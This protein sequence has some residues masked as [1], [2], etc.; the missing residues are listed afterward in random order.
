M[1]NI[2]YTPET[3]NRMVPS[4]AIKEV[5]SAGTAACLDTVCFSRRRNQNR[6]IGVKTPIFHDAPL[7]RRQSP[8]DRQNWPRFAP[9]RRSGDG[10]SGVRTGTAAHR[11]KHGRCVRPL[12]VS[13]VPPS[14]A[15]SSVQASVGRS[16]VRPPVAAL[17]VR[18]S[19]AGSSVRRTLQT[20]T[21][22]PP[23]KP[24]KIG[25]FL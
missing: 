16:S 18:P 8:P 15:D 23:R 19:V 13:S 22:N 25:D 11:R 6:V 7:G 21:E 20:Y 9:V 24:H 4:G 1:K 5:T 17:F 3:P 2:P 12:S 14:V 10:L